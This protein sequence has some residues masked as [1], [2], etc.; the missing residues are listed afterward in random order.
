MAGPRP[1]DITG[2][3]MDASLSRVERR[4]WGAAWAAS[5]AGV[6]GGGEA[7][8][9]VRVF[10]DAVEEA[11]GP[12]GVRPLRREGGHPARWMALDYGSLMIHVM[13]AEA[14]AFYRLEQLWD[15]AKH[16]S[17]NKKKR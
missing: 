14:R 10:E 1:D 7:S 15:R 8:V 6:S 12:S 9:Q 16:I 3:S 4:G 17:W 2:G 5:K 13:R 11:L